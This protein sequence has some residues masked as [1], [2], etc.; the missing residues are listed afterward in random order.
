MVTVIF[1]ITFVRGA[2]CRNAEL[3]GKWMVI[4]DVGPPTDLPGGRKL[5]VPFVVIAALDANTCRVTAVAPKFTIATWSVKCPPGLEP[6]LKN[7]RPSILVLLAGP[8]PKNARGSGLE[9]ADRPDACDTAAGMAAVTAIAVMIAP[10]NSRVRRLA[11]SER[12]DD[13]NRATML[14]YFIG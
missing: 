14:A 4:Q 13:L 6:Q 3:L 11:G 5:V 9:M 2:R 8:K 1:K 7:G 10:A 12:P